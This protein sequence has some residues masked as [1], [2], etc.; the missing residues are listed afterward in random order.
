M[1]I[2]ASWPPSSITELTSGCSFSTASE[3]ALTSCTNLAP[4]QRPTFEPP[5]PVM[6]MRV[7]SA[8]RPGTSA[9]ICL[10]ILSARSACLLSWRW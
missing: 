10:S 1:M 5:E 8:P 6:N 4:T 9:S 2:F 3:T 7:L